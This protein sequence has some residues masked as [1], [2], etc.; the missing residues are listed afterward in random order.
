VTTVVAAGREFERLASNRLWREDA[1]PL[2][3][4]SPPAEADAS[5]PPLGVEYLDPLVYGVAAIDGAFFVRVGSR[6]YCV[7]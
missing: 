2:P 4:A 3:A 5:A 1:P 7:R 6:L